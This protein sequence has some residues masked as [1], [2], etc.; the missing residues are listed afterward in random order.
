MNQIEDEEARDADKIKVLGEGQRH[1]YRNR[2]ATL[3]RDSLGDGLALARIGSP[4][5]L[6]RLAVPGADARK[7]HMAISATTENQAMLR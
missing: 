6:E 5:E 1:E 2:A 3:P 4:V 7:E